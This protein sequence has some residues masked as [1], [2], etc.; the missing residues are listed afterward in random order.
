MK[1]ALTR[2]TSA[3][4]ELTTT[5]SLNMIYNTILLILGIPDVLPRILTIR[6]Q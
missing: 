3:K 5:D 4:F 6:F 2:A 1:K